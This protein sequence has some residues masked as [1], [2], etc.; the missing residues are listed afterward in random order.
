MQVFLLIKEVDVDMHKE[1]RVKK[2][3]TQREEM[4]PV[5]VVWQL[6]NMCSLVTPTSDSGCM[7]TD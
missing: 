5:H 3:F 1:K 2:T 6:F 7:D 4:L